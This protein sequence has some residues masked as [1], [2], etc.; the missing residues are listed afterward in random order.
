MRQTHLSVFVRQLVTFQSLLNDRNYY[1]I[2]VIGP[3]MP[4]ISSFPSFSKFSIFT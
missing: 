4:P 3:I 1:Y 2:K